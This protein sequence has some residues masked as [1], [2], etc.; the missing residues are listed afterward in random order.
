MG[1][2]I[3]MTLLMFLSTIMAAIVAVTEYREKNS[4]AA[5]GWSC[6]AIFSLAAFF[7]NLSNL[8]KHMS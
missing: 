7:Q 6:A 5:W 4:S 1:H 8:L 2:T 3:F